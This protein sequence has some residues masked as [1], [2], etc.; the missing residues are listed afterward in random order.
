MSDAFF[1]ALKNLP[2]QK[3]ATPEYRLYYD[4]DSGTPLFYSMEEEPGTYITIDK[5]IYNQGNYHCLVEKGKII[6]LNIVGNYRK[7][8]P[9]D[10]GTCTHDTN[11]MIVSNQGTHWKLR[12]Y[13]D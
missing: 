2:E 12:T 11:V 7:L 13:E 3:I 10:S 5:T 1:Q 9:A 4:P 6:N 8:V